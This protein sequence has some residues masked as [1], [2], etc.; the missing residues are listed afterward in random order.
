MSARAPRCYGFT[1]ADIPGA[2]LPVLECRR[3]AE[4]R[5]WPNCQT[6][7]RKGFKFSLTGTD[8]YHLLN[9]PDFFHHLQLSGSAAVHYPVTSWFNPSARLS[10][11][12]GNYGTQFNYYLTYSW[13]MRGIRD[14]NPAMYEYMYRKIAMTLNLDLMVNFIEITGFCKTYVTPFMDF[15][16]GSNDDGSFDRLMTVGGEGI[17]ILDSHPSYPIRGSL[18]FNADHLV[19]WAKGEMDLTDVE[20]EIFIGLYFLY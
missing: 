19:K 11:V 13:N 18:G 9:N 17:V 16:L 7:I 20:F 12:V 4:Q 3:D 8:T 6:F 2:H 15:F 1:R 10:F 5:L 14:D